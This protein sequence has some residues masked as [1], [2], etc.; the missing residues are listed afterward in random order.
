LRYA[1]D[2]VLAGTVERDHLDRTRLGVG[3]ID[4]EPRLRG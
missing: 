4:P 2:Y 1:L 3:I